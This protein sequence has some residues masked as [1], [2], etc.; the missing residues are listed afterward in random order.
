[1]VAPCLK[2]SGRRVAYLLID[3]LR[4]E[5]GIALHKQLIEDGKVEIQA[6]FAQL[7]TITPVGMA[8]LL[9]GAGNELR[10]V[11]QN[12]K[13]VP[14][15]GEVPLKNVTDR[16]NLLKSRYGQRFEQSTL[17]DFIKPKFKL[18]SDVELLVIRSTE[19]DKPLET[20]PETTLE[21]IGGSL[22][23]IRAAI[24][25]LAEMGFDDAFIVT[26][27]GFFLNSHAE[28]GDLGTKQPGI[29][30]ICMIAAYWVTG[31]PI[32]RTM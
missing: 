17:S 3:A 22:K 6:A 2:E 25:K 9:P 13:A 10:I 5:L 31:P 15:L 23:R 12:D 32:Q 20:S 14:M 11:K 19:L 29:G 27:H 7:P 4:Y 24:H 1:M 28:A 30:S 26:D 8:S 18:N 16:M 21:L